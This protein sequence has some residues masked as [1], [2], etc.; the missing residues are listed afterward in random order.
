MIQLRFSIT[1]NWASG[2]LLIC[3]ILSL[4]LTGSVSASISTR[5]GTEA[6]LAYMP[7]S[8]GRH[9]YLTNA[10]YSSVQAPSACSSGYHMAS[11][12]EI[13]DISN[14]IYDFKHPAA[15][16]KSDSG[17]GPPSHWLG[18]IRTGYDSSSATIAGKGNCNTWTSVSPNDNGSMV[19]LSDLWITSP[20]DISTWMATV[21]PCDYVAPVW[22]VMDVYELY[23][24]LI[25]K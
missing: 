23:L 13:L 24:P 11:L 12:W 10:N 3:L 1:R 18:W 17:H 7:H 15:Y 16:T 5:S 19:R 14:I 2:V 4:G 20:G 6:T 21:K 9:V 22:C 25:L 8:S